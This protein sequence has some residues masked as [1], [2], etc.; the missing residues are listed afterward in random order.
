MAIIGKIRAWEQEETKQTK[1]S[2][3]AA[4]KF[5]ILVA[6][7]LPRSESGFWR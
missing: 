2:V 4:G 7:R 3:T 1:N 5:V 6:C